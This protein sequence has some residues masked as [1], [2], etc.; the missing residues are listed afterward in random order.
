MGTGQCACVALHELALS[1]LS[2][3]DRKRMHLQ[4]RFACLGSFGIGMQKSRS[5]LIKQ[6]ADKQRFDFRDESHIERRG[7]DA[8]L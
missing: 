6:H 8:A 1:G 7:P 4:D 2:R 3:G 5:T